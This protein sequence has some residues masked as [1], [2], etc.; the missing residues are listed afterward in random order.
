MQE[1]TEYVNQLLKLM[2]QHNG[3]SACEGSVGD[4]GQKGH[5]RHLLRVPDEGALDGILPFV[6]GVLLGYPFVYCVSAETVNRAC[7]WLSTT[8]LLL[9]GCGTYSR[10]KACLNV[11]DSAESRVHAMKI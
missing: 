7:T 8:E 5:S 11:W 10:W 2:H 1:Y 6:N 3:A 4:S 9:C